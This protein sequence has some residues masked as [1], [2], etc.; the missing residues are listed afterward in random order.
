MIT[1]AGGTARVSQNSNGIPDGAN[2]YSGGVNIA[3]NGF[4]INEQGDVTV[5]IGFE[6]SPL[7]ISIGAS[8][9]KIDPNRL[10]K[11]AG[12]PCRNKQTPF[13]CK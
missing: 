3:G 10:R 8:P 5:S 4:S 6:L 9:N 7:P 12:R 1:S 11:C 2:E 13:E